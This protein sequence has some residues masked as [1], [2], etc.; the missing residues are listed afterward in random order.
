VGLATAQSLSAQ[1]VEVVV[2]EYNHQKQEISLGMKQAETNPWDLVEEH[3]YHTS[4]LS[5]YSF[6]VAALAGIG[7]LAGVLLLVVFWRPSEA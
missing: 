3:T 7:L 2:L 5:Y 6:N 1:G 4:S